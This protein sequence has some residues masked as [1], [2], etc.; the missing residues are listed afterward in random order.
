MIIWVIVMW[1]GSPLFQYSTYAIFKPFL[2]TCLKLREI[3]SSWCCP[4]LLNVKLQ[5]YFSPTV[6]TSHPLKTGQLVSGGILLGIVLMGTIVAQI[7]RQKYG[8]LAP[9]SYFHHSNWNLNYNVTSGV[10]HWMHAYNLIWK[11]AATRLFWFQ[12]GND[13]TLLI[14]IQE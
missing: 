14:L 13:Y 5:L 2:I 7:L 3:L 10:S 8:E 11:W 4:L 6:Y 9:H 12:T 1:A